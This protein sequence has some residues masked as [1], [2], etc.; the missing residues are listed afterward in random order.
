MRKLVLAR[1]SGALFGGALLSLML[2]PATS[3]GYAFLGGSLDLGQRDFRV[4]DNFSDPEA[5]DNATPDPNFP[6]ATG[7][8][9][10][11]WKAVA[12]W[13]S[14][15]RYDGIGDPTQPLGL[16]SGGANFDSTYQGLAPSIGDADS[17]VF[18][19]LAG[20]GGGVFAF[21]E[22]PIQDGWR[23]LFYR[24]AAVW[25][26]GPGATQ[27]VQGQVHMD[28]QGV[29]AHE[30]GHA[31]GLA[32][33]LDTS[34]TMFSVP[35]GTVSHFRSIEAD[36]QAGVQA[37]YG[38][39]PP[40][41]PRVTGYVV[42]GPT[43]RIQGANFSAANNTVWLTDGGPAADG[44]PLEVPG[45]PSNGSEIVLPLPAAAVP[46][47]LLVRNDQSGGAALSNAFPFDPAR[48]PCAQPQRY[49]VPKT[50]SQGVPA[51]LFFSGRPHLVTNDLSVGTAGGIP[52]A[53]CVLFSGPG[54]ASVPFAG[55]TLLVAGPWTRHGVQAFDF[56]GSATFTI[57]IDASMVGTRRC[58]Q[59]WFQDAADPFGVGL[60]DA[61]AVQFCP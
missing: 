22:L 25:H 57:P 48:N 5:N 55:G 36:D 40:S 45:L 24:D 30:Y 37:L 2:A 53:P 21:T 47:D 14:A 8:R 28:L 54:P 20:A 46:G 16:G 17:N 43:L 34:A 13:G 10:A 33:S 39:A 32:H 60:T 52:D 18:G 7:A 1:A 35:V 6:G 49:G 59:I 50:N 27:F 42:D 41:K 9:L 12:E 23:I 11:I 38:A 56:V 26:D 29:A 3:E 44:T 31:L 61:L 19:E 4:F 15:P 58:Y 51:A